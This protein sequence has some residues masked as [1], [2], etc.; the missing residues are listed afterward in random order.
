MATVAV[1]INID[2]SI[3][4]LAENALAWK[5]GYQATLPDGTVNPITI[6]QNAK[7]AIR[8]YVQNAIADYQNMQALQRVVPPTSNLIS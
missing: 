3:I 4:P 1:T 7:Q 5:T 2:S 8:Q 6:G